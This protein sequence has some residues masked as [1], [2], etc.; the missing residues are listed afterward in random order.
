MLGRSSCLGGSYILSAENTRSSSIWIKMKG[1]K[2]YPF[3]LQFTTTNKGF[4][5]RMK[6]VIQEK[7]SKGEC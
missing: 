4:L 7:D 6:E 5:V 3:A 1:L 2:D